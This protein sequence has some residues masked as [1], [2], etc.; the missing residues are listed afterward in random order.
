MKRDP[1]SKQ[2]F[3]CLW[4]GNLFTMISIE[5][6]DVPAPGWCSLACKAEGERAR[7]QEGGE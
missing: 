3:F 6:S 4:C 1:P 7:A 2:Q 5:Y